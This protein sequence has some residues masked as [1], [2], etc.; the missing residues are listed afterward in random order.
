MHFFFFTFIIFL[1]NLRYQ[2]VNKLSPYERIL[3]HRMYSD[4]NAQFKGIL[5]KSYTDVVNL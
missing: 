3:T 2:T 1:S 4:N 5:I